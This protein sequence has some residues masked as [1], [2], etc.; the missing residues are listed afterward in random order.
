MKEKKKIILSVLGILMLV[1]VTV[2]VTYAVFTYTKL[3]TTE[4]TVTTGTL[5]FLYTEN[6][7]IGAGI[8]IENAFPVSD[9]VG[10]GYDT[11]K[12]VFDFSVEATNS[13]TEEIP[14]EVTLRK[15]STSTVNNK[16]VKVYLTDMTDDA[17]TEI[18]APSLYSD[19][20]Q[21]N[22]DVGDEIEKTIYKGTVLGDELDYLKDFRLRMWIDEKSNQDDINGKTFT[23][24]VNVYSNVPLVSEEELNLRSSVKIATIDANG[25][26]LTEVANQNYQYEA[27]LPRG[28]TSTTINIETENPDAAVEVEKLESLAYSND[29]VVKRLS[30]TETLPLA[31]GENYFKVKVISANKEN[32]K[33]YIIRIFVSYN[34]VGDSVLS[35]LRDNDLATGNYTFEANGE[36]YPVH[37]YTYD[38]DQHWTTEDET[39]FGDEKDV[40]TASTYAQNMVIVKV[41]G[42]VTIDSGVTVGPKYTSY[43]GPKGFTLYVTGTLTNNGTIDNSHGAKAVGQNVYL[44]KNTD[45]TYEY[46][47]AVGASGGAGYS[48]YR[49]GPGNVGKTG[50]SRGTGG[51]GSGGCWGETTTCGGGNAGTSYS[52]GTG[53]GGGYSTVGTAGANYG[54][55]G[56]T[57]STRSGAFAGGGAGNPGGTG[58]AK[59]GNG[60]GGLLTIYAKD[61]IN[62]GTVKANGSNGG[63]ADYASGGSSGGGSINIFYTSS[64]TAGT[65]ERNGGSAVGGNLN[66]GGAG[67]AGTVTYTQITN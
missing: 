29:S 54:G 40:A 15:K 48:K 62:L 33:E 64:Y 6:T 19:L 60:T 35:I 38:V 39:T 58:S 41:K 25:T 67:G 23:A 8:N 57:G 30:I 22:V 11:D 51:G 55:I 56:G 66:K 16:N 52:G 7:G 28:T 4:N 21:T 50:S 45:G 61:Y 12:Y 1:L 49:G 42:D 18:L 20:P 17:D 27:T 32:N 46:V 43:G 13:G 5:K 31:D 37:L 3:G 36:E 63:F 9:T 59:G 53:G 2:G 65:V 47:P 14:Y 26:S 24:L 44:Y 34:I 10:M